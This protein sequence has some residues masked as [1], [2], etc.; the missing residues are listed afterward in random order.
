MLYVLVLNSEEDLIDA[1]LYNKIALEYFCKDEK[2]K[3]QLESGNFGASKSVLLGKCMRFLR[4]YRQP[5]TTPEQAA[6][7]KLIEDLTIKCVTG[8]EK[9]SV[10]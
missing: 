1:E 4:I 5:N 10:K 3:E 6:S 8:A 9:S 7:L 2:F